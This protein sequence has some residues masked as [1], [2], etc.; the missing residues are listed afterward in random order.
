[1]SPRHHIS[2]AAVVS[3]LGCCTVTGDLPATLYQQVCAKV[4]V[5]S[6][7]RPLPWPAD[8]PHG[9]DPEDGAAS[10]EE[11]LTLAQVLGPLPER[12]PG[13]RRPFPDRPTLMAIVAA[14]GALADSALLSQAE[15]G[16]SKPHLD[17]SR[18]GVVVGTCFGPS[19]TV[20][21]YLRTLITEGP[22]Q[23]SPIAF[24]RAVAS[25]LVGEI[26]RRHQLKGPS[27]VLLGA[28]ILGYALDLLHQGAA[29]A[30]LCV[31]VDEVRDLHGWAY[32]RTGLLADGLVLGEG[33][34]ALLLERS[35]YLQQRG[36]PALA[37]VV[38]YTAGFCPSSVNR[39]SLVSLNSLELSM[40]G[41]LEATGQPAESVGLVV[42]LANGDDKLRKTEQAAIRLCLSPAAEILWPKHT[43]G[44]TFGASEIIGALVGTLAL[45]AQTEREGPGRC[46]VVNTA[47]VG[48]MVG[49]V[50]LRATPV[51]S[52]E[53]QLGA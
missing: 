27:T 29:D 36:G 14:D 3:G 7:L 39:L 19:H 34:A 8:L 41:L 35:S 16:P 33:A 10:T 44:E 21:R 5:T 15:A 32:Q 17:R 37:Q 6:Y 51:G 43:L 22:A 48:G 31:G 9:V 50:L 46:V 42:G 26:C 30:V 53:V 20:E 13:L 23:V 2:E 49:S 25:S 47:Q 40:T 1:M 52:R 24:S 4:P 28:S 12:L 11:T 18:I 38:D 45:G